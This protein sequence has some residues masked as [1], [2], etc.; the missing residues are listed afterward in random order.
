[1]VHSRAESVFILQHYFASKPFSAAREAFSNTYPDKELPNK[2]TEHR[3]VNNV[4]GHKNL[5]V[6][7]FLDI[8]CD[9]CKAVL[10]VLPSI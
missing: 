3:L 6:Y 9:C 2:T 10:Q 8:F 1:M 4:S 7:E 5:R